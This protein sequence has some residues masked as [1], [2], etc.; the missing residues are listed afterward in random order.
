MLNNKKI[1]RLRRDEGFTF[2]EVVVA[3]G[4]MTLVILMFSTVL[5]TSANLQKQIF[6][7][8]SVDR[9]LAYESEQ[10]N[11][12]R[13]DNLMLKPEFFAICNIDGKRISTQSIEPGPTLVSYD[14]IELS[15][16]REIVWA[17]SNATVDCT[18]LNKNRVE[19]KKISITASWLD[20]GETKTKT[21]DI[22]RSKWAEAPI[23]NFGAPDNGVA[24]FYEDTLAQTSLWCQEYSYNG[25]PTDPGNASLFLSDALEISIA[26]TNAICGVNLQ[27]LT[28]G[29][30]YTVVAEITLAADSTPLT[31]TSEGDALGS[32]IA[33]KANQVVRLSYNFIADG[34]SKLVGLKKPNNAI[35]MTG[36]K[37]IVTEFKVYASNN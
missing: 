28:A 32:G 2:V 29:T 16:T 3:T 11:S 6:I 34:G 26:N 22:V 15:I 36:S 33:S 20:D 24:L 8:Q 12:I 31:L 18:P 25:L 23:E 21:L 19:P 10:I 17:N 7:T 30:I 1:S 27:G 13:W 9:A 37:A 4:I 14:N 35:W 5:I